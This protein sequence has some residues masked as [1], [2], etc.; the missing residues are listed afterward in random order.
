MR[1]AE[2]EGESFLVEYD[3]GGR[4]V[5]SAQ[6]GTWLNAVQAPS[7]EYPDT[8]GEAAQLVRDGRAVRAVRL[9][10]GE[11]VR[12]RHGAK[13]VGLTAAVWL[14]PYKLGILAA[15]RDPLLDDSLAVL[16]STTVSLIGM[17]ALAWANVYEPITYY[18]SGGHELPLRDIPMEPEVP[19]RTPA[20]DQ[21]DAVKAEYGRLLSDV[22]HRIEWSALFDASVPQTR[23]FAMALLAWDER[24][25]SATVGDL[26]TLAARVVSAFQA[27]RAE[28]ERRGLNHLDRS[29]RQTARRALKALRLAADESATREE[30]RAAL[31]RAQELLG[32]LRLHFLPSPED[33]PRLAAG[34]HL[35]ELPWKPHDS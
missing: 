2:V 32:S 27:A 18:S 3:S 31:S 14:I 21:V 4:I 16:A 26:A 7:R 25:E 8:L 6:E 23:A 15:M 5:F 24:E 12:R 11:L 19:A 33:L 1:A 22:I 9:P 29:D 28:A 17:T 35:P 10:P 30:R 13:A 20:H 34:D